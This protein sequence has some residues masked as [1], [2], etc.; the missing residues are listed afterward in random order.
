MFISA[1]FDAHVADDMS[2]LALTDNDYRWV[3][4]KLLEIARKHSGGRVL[5][6]L[7]GGYEPSVLA[8]S[9]VAHINVLIG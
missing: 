2:H 7:E 4:E 8:R 3:T 5:S 1:G 6:M 9:V